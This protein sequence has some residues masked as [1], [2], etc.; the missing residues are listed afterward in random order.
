MRKQVIIGLILTAILVIGLAYPLIVMQ[1]YNPQGKTGYKS[2]VKTI[3]NIILENILVKSNETSRFSLNTTHI[4]FKF[5]SSIVKIASCS[6]NSSRVEVKLTALANIPSEYILYN[7]DGVKTMIIIGYF[8]EIIL[9]KKIDYLGLDS[10]LSYILVSLNNTKY[11]YI[12]ARFTGSIVEFI[13]NNSLINAIVVRLEES[14]M[15]SYMDYS[16]LNYTGEISFELESY[17]S[18][19][20]SRINISNYTKIRV[21]RENIGGVEEVNI[22]GS[23]LYEYYYIDSG[24]YESRARLHIAVK[25]FGSGIRIDLNRVG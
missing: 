15:E 8:V 14:L 9:P 12:E 24:Y 5:R 3:Y 21:V 11:N 1:V 7:E 18:I 25:G 2:L 22:N 10:K 6:N 20:Y 19:S 13:A 4:V 17:T 23:R 16:R